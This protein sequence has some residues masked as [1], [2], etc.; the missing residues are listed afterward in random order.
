MAGSMITKSLNW[1]IPLHKAEPSK[2]YEITKS[3]IGLNWY[4]P[5]H[6]AEHDNALPQGNSSPS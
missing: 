6:K 4:I 1:Y 2:N 5:L 3:K